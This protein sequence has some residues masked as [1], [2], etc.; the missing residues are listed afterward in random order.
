MFK[1]SYLSYIYICLGC[2]TP[3]ACPVPPGMYSLYGKNWSKQTFV[4]LF[5]AG[6]GFLWARDL[7]YSEPPPHPPLVFA[8]YSKNPLDNLYL[9]NLDLSIF[10]VA[11]ASF[12]PSQSILCWGSVKSPIGKRVNLKWKRTFQIF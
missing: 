5:F 9:K 6:C 12:T 11:D 10:F 7:N 3:V 1:E 4:I 2:S 8:V